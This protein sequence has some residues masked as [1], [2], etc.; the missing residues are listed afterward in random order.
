MTDKIL[1]FT[2]LWFHNFGVANYLQKNSD[3]EIYAIIDV[4]DRAKQFFQE[5]KIVNYGKVWYFMDHIKKPKIKP[6]VDYLK[7][8]EEKYGINLW[9][10]A[11]SDRYLHGFNPYH[12]FSSDEILSLLEQECR[13][14]EKILDEVKP[15]FLSIFFTIHHHQELLRQLCVAR[16]IKVLMLV[17]APFGH[18]MMLTQ[19][20]LIDSS[21]DTSSMKEE[22]NMTPD[23][24]K[25]YKKNVNFLGLSKDYI[26]KNFEAKS[27]LR[28]FSILRYFFASS[29]E[30]YKNRYSNFG[31]TKQSVLRKKIQNRLNRT[32]R[33]SFINKHFTRNI[34]SDPPFVY[35]PLHYEP[36]RMLSI[37]AP[38]RTGQLEI[39]KSI[40]K[41][42]PIEYELYVK[43]HPVMNTIG[44]RSLSFYKEL[45][46]LPNVKL[47]HPSV[48]PD[49]I[50]SKCSLTVTINGT[51]GLESLFFQKPTVVFNENFYSSLSSVS[52]VRDLNDLPEIIRTSLTKQIDIKELNRFIQ[53]IENNTFFLNSTNLQADFAF[54]FGLKGP[55]QDAYLPM[56]EIQTFLKDYSK[57]F[58]ILGKE[59]IKKIQELKKIS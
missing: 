15:D 52:V 21:N 40:S 16:G 28:Y 47:I 17:T 4:E 24:L 32:K 31:K 13:F 23:E 30:S 39:I 19:D 49:E 51:T 48:S 1:F 37:S 9:N 25:N 3:S 18:Y 45:M 29:T 6:N 46:D 41:S 42:I 7:T 36:E 59:H 10:L 27:S 20:G 50:L 22:K 12:K 38:F 58:E 43:E 57:D 11:Y 55:L 56:N 44:W 5:Q 14:Y 8:I 34:E 2:D 54:R 26:K 53:H 35:F 33:I